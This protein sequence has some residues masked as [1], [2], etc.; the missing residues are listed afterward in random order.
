MQRAYR[1]G[2]TLIELLVVIS[3][4]AILSLVG[5]VTFSQAAVNSR[6]AR[7]KSDLAQLQQAL[8][9]YR[10]DLGAYPIPA[11]NNGFTSYTAMI[12]ELQSKGYFNQ[13]PQY[14]PLGA[15]NDAYTYASTTTTGKTFNICVTLE[16]TTPSTYCINN[17]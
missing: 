7:R 15:A 9:I 11:G 5:I 12:N 16:R 6:N 4:I 1:K 10:S 17:P 2:F 14:G 3:I 13:P 8:V